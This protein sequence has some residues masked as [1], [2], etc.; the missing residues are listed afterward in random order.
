[1]FV[2][3]C[4]RARCAV[5][6]AC[7]LAAPAAGAQSGAQSGATVS[8]LLLNS[9]TG[10]PVPGT[11]T[12]DELKREVSVAPDGTFTFEHV[13]PGAYHVSVRAPKFRTGR[14][15]ITVTAGG[16]ALTL[17]IDPEVHYEEIVSVSP[18]ARSQFESYQPTTVLAGQE[19]D[20]QVEMSL[21]GTLEGQ[22]GV[23]SRSFGPAPARPVIRGL[24]GDR[25][26][27]LQDGQRVGDLSSQSGDHGVPINPAAARRIEV[28]RGPATLLYGANAIG[29]LVN[30]ITEE[31]PRTPQ[32]GAEGT[33]TLDVGSGARE[34]SGAVDLHV[35]NGRVAMHLGG[36]ARRSGDVRTPEGKVENS[37]SR[38]GMASIGLSWTGARG[39]FGGSY[40]YDDTRYGVPL[41]EEGRI[42]LTPRRHAFSLRSDVRD[43]TGP[44]EGLRA[45]AAHRRYRHDEL[46]GSDVSTRFR[47]DT[48][49][50]ELLAA[51]RRFGRL[52]GSIGAWALDRAFSAEGEEALAPPVDQN[53]FAAFFYE[54]L[55][56]PHVTFQFGARA[57]RAEFRPLGELARDF[58]NV[59]GSFGLLVQ[60]PGLDDRL[61]I[62]VSVA[63]A[64]R[65][66]A[67]E[68]L[69]FF[70]EHHGNFAFEVGNP[71]LES[72][73]GLGF[74]IS[75]R[76][77]TARMSGEATYFRNDIGDYI[78]RNPITEEE[79]EAREAEWEERFGDRA[80]AHQGH[81][82]GGEEALQFIEFVAADSVLH[83]FEAHAD[84]QILESVSAEVGLDYVR[85]TVKA[86]DQPL[87]RIP[88]LR[89]RTGLRYH[90]NAF[91]AGGEAVFA[92]RQDRVFGD[93]APT[94]GYQTLKLY[95]SYS[96]VTGNV[97]NTVTA[98][99]DNV[100][101]ELYRNHLSLIKEFVPE[102]GRSF[103]LLYN[104]RF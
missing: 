36:S 71:Q 5:V 3:A 66:P 73:K 26:L 92:A 101:N 79:F 88:P 41:I 13:P 62:A 28:I 70:G 77:R 46:T 25:V 67:L 103:R 33:A 27:I 51:Q 98:R 64:A 47:N 12:I 91:Q 59:S 11:V 7:L 97:T 21:G 72:E 85:G 8:G 18:E 50:L 19:L 82:H 84:A 74:D 100:T 37:Q 31:I 63:R 61:T 55:E 44:F 96:F 68:E 22:P 43:L 29:G 56:W 54:E 20:K 42:E 93:E 32:E 87:P 24:D 9:V 53:G 52:K 81:G 39:Y 15:E 60:P 75:L 65:N 80:G 76:W 35:G 45:T 78:F 69:Y 83:G 14:S 104:V 86:L 49:E 10:A 99:A 90:K 89:V 57:D 102:M 34:G 94:P 40:G 23:A 30:V 6:A 2:R 95:S 1:M 58:T 16:P 17:T 38:N 4:S 48:T